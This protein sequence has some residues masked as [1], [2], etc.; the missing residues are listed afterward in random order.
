MP[1]QT[2][3]TTLDR[4]ER[5]MRDLRISVTDRCNF[6]CPYCMPAEIYGDRYEFM[7]RPDLLTYEE[8]ERIA[9]ITAELG[10][11]KIRITGGEPLLRT[12]LP[13]LIAKLADI[14]G[15]EDLALTTNGY[16]LPELAVSL[17]KAGLQRLTVSVDALDPEVFKKM[18]GR[19]YPVEKVMAGIEAAEAAGFSPLKI[20][21]MVQRGVNDHCLVE[22]ARYFKER[23]HIMRFIEYM[24]VGT[25]NGW[26]ADDV[27]S[28]KEIHAAIDA[29]MPLEPADPNYAGEVSRRYKYKDGSGEIGL[30]ASVSQP[31]CGGCTR[32]R[33][34]TDGQLI[35]CLFADT[36]R[37]L[38]GP[39]RSGADDEELSQIV[40]GTW[41]MREDRY[42]E[43]RAGLGGRSSKIEMYQIG[44]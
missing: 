28:A 5:P 10:V 13:S 17:R 42:S 27:V 29:E 36:G 4:F 41:A 22:L 26:H 14:D 15:I 24:D 35:T 44:G 25:L 12:E 16:L 37:D 39:M 34:S 33:L 38:R 20:N 6:R 11:K 2:D 9:R 23:G 19:N 43:E 1:A 32:A 40:Q 30:I 8:I 21:C 7:P 18:N 31:F 3:A